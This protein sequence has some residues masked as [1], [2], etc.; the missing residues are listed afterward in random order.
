M[1]SLNINEK[2]SKEKLRRFLK[3]YFLFILNIIEIH[4]KVKFMSL[5]ISKVLAIKA[6]KVVQHF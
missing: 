2:L 6:I 1:K 5:K 4:W 3:K